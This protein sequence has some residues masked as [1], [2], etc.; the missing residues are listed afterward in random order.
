MKPRNALLFLAPNSVSGPVWAPGGQ[1]DVNLASLREGPSTHLN[2]NAVSQKQPT[3][4]SLGYQWIWASTGV[5]E[6]I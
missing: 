6:S 5:T 3:E 2:C 1:M 4:L